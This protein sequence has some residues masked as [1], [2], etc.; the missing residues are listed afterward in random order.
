[1]KRENLP[2]NL[3]ELFNSKK[4]FTEESLK[5]LNY[6]DMTENIEY[7]FAYLKISDM[8]FQLAW[9]NQD[10]HEIEWLSKVFDKRKTTLL[11][12]MNS[13]IKNWLDYQT[14]KYDYLAE[15]QIMDEMEVNRLKNENY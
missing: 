14:G 7:E 3:K 10:T 8:L 5:E 12:A 6:F 15:I 2:S 1:M 13:V 9:I 11:K 4:H